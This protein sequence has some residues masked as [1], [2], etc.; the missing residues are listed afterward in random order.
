MTLHVAHGH[1]SA[2]E[3][4]GEAAPL[5]PSSVPSRTRCTWPWLYFVALLITTAVI[6]DIGESLYAAPRVRLFESVICTR[7]YSQTDV[8]GDRNGSIPE[9]LCKVNAVQDKLAS[10]I[11]W[12]FFFDS[13]P[14]I[15]LPIPF[16]YLADKHGRKWI[17]LLAMT[18]Y[19]M[20]YAW[21]Q[22]VVSLMNAVK[23]IQ[24]MFWLTDAFVDR[25]GLCIY[26]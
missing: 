16:G 6:S 25:S 3:D 21:T 5:L 7:Y 9:H 22:F 24:E 8:L 23:T 19:T 18:G 26:L 14:A 15:L 4:A 17:L 10:L 12:Q 1:E 2:N 13:I 20:S 11:G